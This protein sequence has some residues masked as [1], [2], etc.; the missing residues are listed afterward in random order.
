VELLNAGDHRVSAVQDYLVIILIDDLLDQAVIDQDL[1]SRVWFSF[2]PDLYFP[3]VSV[4]IGAFPL[5][6]KETVAG[7][8]VHR[9]IDPDFHCSPL[10]PQGYNVIMSNDQ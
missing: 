8:N 5:V 9:F 10:G 1:G 3:P 6:I 4:E 7:I 2:Y